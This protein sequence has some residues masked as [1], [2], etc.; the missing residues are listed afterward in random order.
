[1]NVLVGDMSLVGPRPNVKRGTDVYT[2][3]E[4]HILDVQPGITDF[5]SIV[6]SDEGFIL[7]DKQDP[8]LAYDQLIRPWKS[9]L[10]LIYI[11]NLTM[12]LDIQIILLTLLALFSKPTALGFVV[13]LLDKLGAN[14][15]VKTIA[16]R[17]IPLYSIPP[18]HATQLV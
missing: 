12:L 11:R 5:S 18:P 16:S 6:F 17:S 15:E 2:E 10:C 13:R 3:E 1:M 9:Q 7:S 14:E 4:K 8:D